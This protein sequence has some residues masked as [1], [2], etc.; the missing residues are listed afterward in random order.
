MAVIFISLGSNLDREVQLRAAVRALRASFTGVSLSPVY[1]SAAVGFDGP[2][3]YNLVARAETAL[4]PA[5]VVARLHAIE[6]AQGR[7]RHADGWHSRTLDLDLL[8]YDALVEETAQYALP[9]P[10]IT[11]HAFVLKPLADLAGTLRHPLQAAR[12]ADLW[13][14][15]DQAAQPL[16]RVPFEFDAA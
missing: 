10:E 16:T 5:A 1:E 7:Q 6:D 4:D 13:A 12:Y 15:F 8:L 11:S 14:A 9:R 3:F 2:P